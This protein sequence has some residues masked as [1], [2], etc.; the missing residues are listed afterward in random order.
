MVKLAPTCLWW[1]EPLLYTSHDT[2]NCYHEPVY[3]WTVPN[4]SITC[5]NMF[6]TYCFHSIQNERTMK[7]HEVDEVIYWLCMVW[8]PQQQ[9]DLFSDIFTE[10]Q[11]STKTCSTKKDVRH[12]YPDLNNTF[13]V[14]FWKHICALQ[15]TLCTK[16]VHSGYL[17]FALYCVLFQILIECTL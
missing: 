4:M 12:S 9:T 7:V 6:E 17:D 16:G 5:L 1:T 14:D 8:C 15:V 10:N 2:V 3:L 13:L 11:M